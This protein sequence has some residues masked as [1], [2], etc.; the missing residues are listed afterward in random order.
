LSS[1]EHRSPLRD[2]LAEVHGEEYRSFASLAEAK[3]HNDGT[4]VLEGDDGGQ[5]YLVVRAGAVNCSEDVLARLLHDIDAREWPGNDANSARVCY[6][7]RR[8]GTAVPGGMG[9]G[10]VSEELWLHPRLRDLAASI[11]AVLEGRQGSIGSE[12]SGE[13][14]A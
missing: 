10:S 14:A 4:V 3:A 8:V 6:E 9:G 1:N 11:G 13:T 7:L 5:I 2:L 12:N